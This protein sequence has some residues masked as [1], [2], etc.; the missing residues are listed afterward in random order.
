MRL[1]DPCEESFKFSWQGDECLYVDHAGLRVLADVEGAGSFWIDEAPEPL[2][3]EVDGV[4]KIANSGEFS[5]SFLASSPSAG[6]CGIRAALGHRRSEFGAGE[7]FSASVEGAGWVLS[8]TGPFQIDHSGEWAPMPSNGFPIPFFQSVA[9]ASPFTAVL[10]PDQRVVL[11]DTVSVDDIEAL[12][13]R[14]WQVQ[15]ISATEMLDSTFADG[16][17]HCAWVASHLNAASW[18]FQLPGDCQGLIL[19]RTYDRF[20]GRQRSRVLIDGRFV[21]WWYCPRQDRTHRWGV[22]RFGIRPALLPSCESFRFTIDPPAGSP[23]WSFSRLEVLAI[24]RKSAD[25][26]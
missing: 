18:N 13:A 25:N 16:R 12:K 8:A 23:L 5:K 9:S 20:H 10:A 1:L 17:R 21:G 2:I 26:P 11:A 7:P 6:P 22:S 24:C 15:N 19:R 14:H 4:I 3:V